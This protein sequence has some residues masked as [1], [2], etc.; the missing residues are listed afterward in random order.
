M[1]GVIVCKEY[2][3]I[4]SWIDCNT[5]Q[6]MEDLA[7]EVQR[8]RKHSCYLT[9]CKQIQQDIMF[10]KILLL[11]PPTQP[12]SSCCKSPSS[13]ISTPRQVKQRKKY[14][15]LR[16]FLKNCQP[17]CQ[18]QFLRNLD[19]GKQVCSLF[20]IFETVWHIDHHFIVN[21]DCLHIR[22]HVGCVYSALCGLKY[23]SNQKLQFISAVILIASIIELFIDDAIDV[24]KLEDAVIQNM[25]L[26]PTSQVLSIVYLAA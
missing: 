23:S 4:V 5:Q 20:T 6:L 25:S 17:R 22:V 21:C 11:A 15:I 1:G 10:L 14:T 26:T 3:I 16:P 18:T 19:K 12:T 13:T 9:I 7:L 2:A 24:M 8:E